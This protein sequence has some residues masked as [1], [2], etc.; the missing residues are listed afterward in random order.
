M[1]EAS[2]NNGTAADGKAPSMSVYDDP[3]Y[4]KFKGILKG[5]VHVSSK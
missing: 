1:V 5:A 4:E 3:I 2:N